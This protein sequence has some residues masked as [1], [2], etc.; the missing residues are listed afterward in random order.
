MKANVT[1]RG[2]KALSRALRK[3]AELP[4]L[5]ATLASIGAELRAR[6]EANLDQSGLP[7]ALARRLKKSLRED[8][9]TDGTYTLSSDDAFAA[10]VENGTL[11][12]PAQPWL[13]PALMETQKSVRGR[14]RALIKS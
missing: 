8:V 9:Q 13:L 7:P 12:H 3:R 2:S 5:D 11:R 4:G 10:R 1:L 14:F 6:A